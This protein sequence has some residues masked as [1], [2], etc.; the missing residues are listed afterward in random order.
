MLAPGT[1]PSG[2]TLTGPGP[3]TAVSG[4]AT[5]SAT[6]IDRAGNGYTLVAS[7]APLTSA[8]STTFNVTA[9]AA[10]QIA[11]NAGNNQTATAG[12]A[13]AID[14]SVIVRDANGNP[15]AGVAVTFA[16][17]SGGGT[18]VPTTPVTTGTNRSEER[19]VGKEGRSR[20]SPYH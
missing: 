20:G 19:R 6:S 11:I 3:Q 13:V 4:V 8:T 9:G 2:G 17:A 16:V 12:T 18:V 7:S 10:S 5:F 14:P 15:V 1:N